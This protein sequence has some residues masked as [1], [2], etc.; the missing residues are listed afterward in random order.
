MFTGVPGFWQPYLVRAGIQHEGQQATSGHYRAIGFDQWGRAHLW[1]DCAT[2]QPCSN[3]LYTQRHICVLWL[4]KTR[5]EVFRTAASLTTQRAR[6]SS[7]SAPSEPLE[8][9][10][11]NFDAELGFLLAQTFTNWVREIDRK[12]S[13]SFFLKKPDSVAKAPWMSG[14]IHRIQGWKL[15]QPSTDERPLQRPDTRLH[16][17]QNPLPYN[18]YILKIFRQATFVE[19][20]VP[21]AARLAEAMGLPGRRQRKNGFWRRKDGTN[22]YKNKQNYAKHIQNIYKHI[23]KIYKQ[24]QKTLRCSMIPHIFVQGNT[25]YVW[26]HLVYMVVL[27]F[28]LWFGLGWFHSVALGWVCLFSEFLYVFVLNFCCYSFVCQ[29]FVCYS[30]IL[31]CLFCT[32]L[33]VDC[34]LACLLLPDL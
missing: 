28:G 4:T 23:Q 17:K 1:D 33:F 7:G 13:F 6:S 11:G 12:L 14:E 32:H 2:S 3:L 19:L 16:R 9:D 24:I 30:R 10:I 25:L 15:K 34:L 31:T 20:S 26:I 5:E 29:L 27:A 21:L 18:S 22:I 8:P